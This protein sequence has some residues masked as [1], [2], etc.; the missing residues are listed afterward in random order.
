MKEYIAT[1]G[2]THN[3]LKAEKVLKKNDIPFKLMPTPREITASCGLSI[4]FQEQN[5]E[6]I[7]NAFIKSGVKTA[8]LYKKEEDGSYVKM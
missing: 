6:A 8:A 1:F 4:L 7:E 3:A 5:R 2:S